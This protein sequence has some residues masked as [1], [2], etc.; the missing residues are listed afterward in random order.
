MNSKNIQQYFKTLAWPAIVVAV[1]L[2]VNLLFNV[3]AGIVMWG[4]PKADAGLCISVALLGSSVVTSLLLLG[5]KPLGLDTG[6][7]RLG[8]DKRTAAVAMLAIVAGLQVS[9]I[10]NDLLDLPNLLEETFS[11]MIHTVWGVLAIAVF[12]P[13]CEELVFRAGI[14]KPM[15]RAGA[16]PWSAILTSAA[17]FGLIHGNPAQIVFAMLV[18]VVFGIVY[19]RTGSL[20][21]T[22]ACHIFNNTLSVILMLIYSGEEENLTAEKVFGGKLNT[23]IVLL[24]SAAIC[25]VLLRIVW[26]RTQSAAANPQL[27]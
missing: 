7:R 24:V 5:Y 19:A 26:K 8:C 23:F 1:Y 21:I 2:F 27:S 18:G 20:L 6:Y 10:L 9:D 13:V 17:V 4:A 11:S 15:L 22:T 25:L 3:G 14:M 12:G 16:A